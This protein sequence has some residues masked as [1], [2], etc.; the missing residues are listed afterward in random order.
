MTTRLFFFVMLVV[1]G[2]SFAFMNPNPAPNAPVGV[3][4]MLF[5]ASLAGCLIFVIVWVQRSL[6]GSHTGSLDGYEGSGTSYGDFSGW[7]NIDCGSGDGGGG[8]GGGGD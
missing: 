3:L 1:C 6:K 7:S 4:R 2:L 8:D 5:W